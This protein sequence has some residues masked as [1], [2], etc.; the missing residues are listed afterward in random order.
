[1][2]ILNPSSFV[3]SLVKKYLHKYF[4]NLKD[5]DLKLSLWDGDLHLKNLEVNEETIQSELQMPFQIKEGII[6]SFQLHIPWKRITSQPI[7]AKLE[8]FRLVIDLE[9]P[10][11]IKKKKEVMKNV[12]VSESETKEKGWGFNFAAKIA[13]NTQFSLKNLQI[14]ILFRGYILT[15]I[16]KSMKYRAVDKQWKPSYVDFEG[17]SN[18]IRNMG[19]IEELSIFWIKK[20]QIEKSQPNFILHKTEGVIRLFQH[21]NKLKVP[22]N[23]V[24]ISIQIA[25]LSPIKLVLDYDSVVFL[26]QI[27]DFLFSQFLEQE[28]SDEKD[29]LENSMTNN[30]SEDIL[31][32]QVLKSSQKKNDDSDDFFSDS[33]DETSTNQEK[34]DAEFLSMGS[35]NDDTEYFAFEETKQPNENIAFRLLITEMD[36]QIMKTDSQQDALLHFIVSNFLLSTGKIGEKNFTHLACQ[37]I[38]IQNPLFGY[39]M[40]C[41]DLEPPKMD[42]SAIFFEGSLFEKIENPCLYRE[43]SEKWRQSF[44]AIFLENLKVI[45]DI[46]INGKIG[47]ISFLFVYPI[48]EEIF[49]IVSVI[50]LQKIP[51][52]QSRQIIN[53]D[54][55]LKRKNSSISNPQ[56][57]IDQWVQKPLKQINISFSQINIV[58]PEISPK[59]SDV[60]IFCA[61]ILSVGKIELSNREQFQ[62]LHNVFLSKNSSPQEIVFSAISKTKNKLINKMKFNEKPPESRFLFDT[63]KCTVSDV[64][65][66]RSLISSDGSLFNHIHDGQVDFQDNFL[67]NPFTISF[68]IQNRVKEFIDRDLLHTKKSLSQKKSIAQNHHSQEITLQKFRLEIPQIQSQINI[69]DILVLMDIILSQLW[70][71]SLIQSRISTESLDS[72]FDIKSFRESLKILS[73]INLPRSQIKINIDSIFFK[74]STCTRNV[75]K[76]WGSLKSIGIKFAKQFIDGGV[77]EQIILSTSLTKNISQNQPINFFRACVKYPHFFNIFLGSFTFCFDDFLILLFSSFSSFLFNSISSTLS[78]PQKPKTHQ[79]ITKTTST[80]FDNENP[81]FKF[82]SGDP[83]FDIQI[84]P[85]L[86]S[87]SNNTFLQNDTLQFFLRLPE[88][89]IKNK[90]LLHFY[91]KMDNLSFSLYHSKILQK[92][93]PLKI[94]FL[95]NNLY[96]SHKI[97]ENFSFSLDFSHNIKDHSISIST[98][99]DPLKVSIE[100]DQVLL[101]LD[102]IK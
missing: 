76:I 85:S 79:L 37:R 65:L 20:N 89:Q 16:C 43:N 32:P 70:S 62:I 41:G 60:S 56:Y 26:A 13:N 45:E 88:I 2:S 64:C 72:K 5:P 29:L 17:D 55:Q 68:L 47:N 74:L 83:H 19:Q 50:P 52:S 63:I 94:H 34:S 30:E 53:K 73:K 38:S 36:F 6:E 44:H 35:D 58:F 40:I 15:L 84:N 77:D 12:V 95:E 82:L 18:L 86:I 80:Q 93:T 24:G 11:K 96:N 78:S 1:M 7:F 100:D 90:D 97:I 91:L 92:E 99:F 22:E 69:D 67:I 61:V 48:L 27:A 57:I 31:S 10:V 49:N 81:L 46:K 71:S 66:S 59:K 8:G 28:N 75:F 9:N 51:K 39:I 25:F 3:S 33:E 14:D 23:D 101:I 21:I 98:K 4:K 42:P 102:L 54:D 87:V